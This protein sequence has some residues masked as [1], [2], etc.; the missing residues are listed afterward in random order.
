MFAEEFLL[1]ESER[2]KD[3][4]NPTPGKAPAELGILDPGGTA[5]RTTDRVMQIARLLVP[6]V[7]QI[8]RSR[9]VLFVNPKSDAGQRATEEEKALQTPFIVNLGSDTGLLEV[10]PERLCFLK[11]V[12]R[13]HRNWF[14]KT[15]LRK[16]AQNSLLGYKKWNRNN[17]ERM[18]KF[19]CRA[20]RND[21]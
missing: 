1:E 18:V 9:V 5:F 10:P 12:K 11:L 3:G 7:R 14:H 20:R 13:G 21:K 19:K 15:S 17:D 2:R 4:R 6:F 8:F 16:I